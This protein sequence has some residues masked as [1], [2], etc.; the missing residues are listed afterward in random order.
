MNFNPVT[1]QHFFK[2][3]DISSILANTTFQQM[4]KITVPSFKIYKH[5]MHDIVANDKALDLNL[6]KVIKKTKQGNKIYSNLAETL[7][8]G[9]ITLEPEWPSKNDIL[10]YMLLEYHFLIRYGSYGFF[11][12]VGAL[13]L[14]GHKSV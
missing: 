14:I 12:K 10:T 3:D 7:L 6:K 13:V 1:L 4:V 5:K 9:Q 8:D 2:E 11:Y